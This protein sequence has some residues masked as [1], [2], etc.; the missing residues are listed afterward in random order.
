MERAVSGAFY[1]R[2]GDIA[3]GVSDMAGLMAPKVYTQACLGIQKSS[4]SYHALAERRN[5]KSVHIIILDF[6]SS[7]PDECLICLRSMVQNF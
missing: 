7:L 4:Q 5:W 2:D 1:G 6:I 3:V